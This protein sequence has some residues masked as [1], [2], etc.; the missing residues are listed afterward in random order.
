MQIL[1]LRLRELRRER[2]QPQTE[3]AVLPGM[4]RHNYQ[5]MERRKINIPALALC[6]PADYFGLPTEHLLGRSDQ[7]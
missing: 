6:A 1:G 5:R 4:T 2:K 7:R 3:I